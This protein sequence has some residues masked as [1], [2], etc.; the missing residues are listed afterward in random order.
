MG[1]TSRHAIAFLECPVLWKQTPMYTHRYT[2]T[3]PH[4]YVGHTHTHMTFQ[5]STMQTLKGKRMTL[6][7]LS[8]SARLL[9]PPCGLVRNI[10]LS[11]V[12]GSVLPPGWDPELVSDGSLGP[13]TGSSVSQCL[14][15]CCERPLH[16]QLRAI[17]LTSVC[18]LGR[19]SIF[20]LCP[21]TWRMGSCVL[22][23]VL[24]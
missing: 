10:P 1:V 5:D 12:S 9:P 18:W 4:R 19:F 17:T 14:N 23:G 2:Y 11:Y 15:N 16:S 22:M 7:K 24:D 13:P 6:F 20:L 8:S 3:P 21:C